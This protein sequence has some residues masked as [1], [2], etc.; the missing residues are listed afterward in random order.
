MILEGRSLE[1]GDWCHFLRSEVTGRNFRHW[2]TSHCGW[3]KKFKN[4]H[5]H[6]CVFNFIPSAGCPI[7]AIF[8]NKF[9]TT[10]KSAIIQKET[11]CGGWLFGVTRNGKSEQFCSESNSD[12]LEVKDCFGLWMM[13]ERSSKF[14]SQHIGPRNCSQ[15][16][17][18]N[19]C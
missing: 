15:I 8:H 9:T 4:I 13:N 12:L 10:K 14:V 7:H 1:V 18:R 19:I 5:I 17:T 3:W 16:Y 2:G 11:V 6:V